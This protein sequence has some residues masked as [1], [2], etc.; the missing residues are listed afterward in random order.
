[1]TERARLLSD[2]SLRG[3]IVRGRRR[4][5]SAIDFV[6]AHDMRLEGWPDQ[7]V[8]A[9][10]AEHDRAVIAE[11]KQTMIG[12]A[13]L[14]LERGLSFPGLVVVPQRLPAGRA[15]RDVAALV[16]RSSSRPL[17]GRIEYLPIDKA[18]RVREEESEW[19]EVVA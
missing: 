18:W 11:D 4:H 14:R 12:F 7:D 16:E 10:V 13:K 17:H 2:E 1:M 3:Q 15:I 6:I 19:A 8:L 9:W 5:H